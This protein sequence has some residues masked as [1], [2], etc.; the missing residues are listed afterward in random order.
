MHVAGVLCNND[1][2][3]L[4]VLVSS[5]GRCTGWAGCGLGASVVIVLVQKAFVLV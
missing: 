5:A 3:S 4:P 1:F 2:R